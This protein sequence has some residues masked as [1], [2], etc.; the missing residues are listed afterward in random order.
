MRNAERHTEGSFVDRFEKDQN[1]NKINGY[2]CIF[3]LLIH[4]SGDCISPK[5][6]HVIFLGI[7]LILLRKTVKPHDTSGLNIF[8]NRLIKC[9]LR[10]V[11]SYSFLFVTPVYLIHF[12]KIL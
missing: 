4:L 12:N 2:K 10:N 5:L 3:L 7:R 8:L 11:Y 6:T 1:N 9:F